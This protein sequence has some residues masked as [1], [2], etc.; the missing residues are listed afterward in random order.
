MPDIITIENA[1]MER[2]EY[3]DTKPQDRY[4]GRRKFTGCRECGSNFGMHG[5]C[6][7]VLA[8]MYYSVRYVCWHKETGNDEYL[9]CICEACNRDGVIPGG[10][11]KITATEVQA[12]L[13]RN[14]MSPDYAALAARLQAWAD[15]LEAVSWYD[16]MLARKVAKYYYGPDSHS[17]TLDAL[18]QLRGKYPDN[19][20]IAAL[21]AEPEAV[22]ASEDSRNSAG[23]EG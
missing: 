23:L 11:T 15:K 2:Q 17:A 19:K 18:R 4:S 12:W 5:F 21:A 6:R 8:V 13:N 22:L 14:P 9:F 10:F 3:M 20:L 1:A 16:A 7:K